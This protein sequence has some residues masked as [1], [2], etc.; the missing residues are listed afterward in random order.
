M[1]NGGLAS[2]ANYPFVGSTGNA[3]YPATN[4]PAC[5]TVLEDEVGMSLHAMAGC[6]GC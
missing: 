4:T 5:N 2:A 3:A 6:H 1:Q